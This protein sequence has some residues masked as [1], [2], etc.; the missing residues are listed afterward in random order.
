MD[1]LEF[2]LV[3]QSFLFWDIC[4]KEPVYRLVNWQLVD[5][6]FHLLV[7][8]KFFANNS[9]VRYINLSDLFIVY[10]EALSLMPFV[11]ISLIF[12]TNFFFNKFN[13]YYLSLGF[14]VYFSSL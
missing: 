7:L 4:L 3:L 1:S 8:T 12:E 14:G 10:P 2:L 11:S 5:P 9:T 6:D 13:N